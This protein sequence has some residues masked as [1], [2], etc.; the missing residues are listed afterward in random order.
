M[1]SISSHELDNLHNPL[2]TDVWDF[3]NNALNIISSTYREKLKKQE[4]KP[5]EQARADFIQNLERIDSQFP[6]ETCPKRRTGVTAKSVKKTLGGSMEDWLVENDTQEIFAMSNGLTE[7]LNADE[8]FYMSGVLKDFEGNSAYKKTLYVKDSDKVEA[9]C[10]ITKFSIRNISGIEASD[11]AKEFSIKVSAVLKGNKG[12]NPN[13][14][15]KDNQGWTLKKFETNSSLFKDLLLKKVTFEKFEDTEKYLEMAEKEAKIVDKICLLKNPE[16]EDNKDNK[17]NHSNI[18]RLEKEKQ[19]VRKEGLTLEWLKGKKGKSISESLQEYRKSL[20]YPVFKESPQDHAAISWF[21]EACNAAYFQ[22]VNFFRLVFF[23]NV[24][25]IDQYQALNSL[26]EDMTK[27]DAN[28]HETYGR[29]VKILGQNREN[30][31]KKSRLKKVAD[32]LLPRVKE[33]MLFAKPSQDK[34]KRDVDV[35]PPKGNQLGN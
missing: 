35:T 9:H 1:F 11:T 25:K 5:K 18:Q 20:I 34:G 24:K 3:K 4:K 33:I 21:K 30:I 15:S 32:D 7:N 29:V 27:E 10:D 14:E 17:D 22:V 6:K 19:A 2:K 8:K 31:D 23:G 12:T 13:K 26:K 28:L 16:N